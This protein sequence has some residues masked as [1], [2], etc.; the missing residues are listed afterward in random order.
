MSTD[1]VANTEWQPYRERVWVTLARTGTIAAV[2]GTIFAWRVHGGLARWAAAT[3]LALWPALGGHFVE[4]FY[5]NWL[6]PRL[7]D[8][9]ALR[10]AVRICVWFVGGTLLALG[11]CVTAL[12]LYDSPPPWSRLLAVGGV[13]FIAIELV[14]HFVLQSRGR[15]NFYNDRG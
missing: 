12:L 3:L 10:A 14:V 9:R 15:P 11:M 7:P 6:R 1:H 8:S 13:A 5:L 4:L 2:L